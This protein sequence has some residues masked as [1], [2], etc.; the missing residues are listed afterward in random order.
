MTAFALAVFVVCAAVTV[1][2]Y[3]GYPA[4]IWLLAKLRPRPIACT[5]ESSSKSPFAPLPEDA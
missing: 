4:L 3:F 1:Y 2:I 5:W